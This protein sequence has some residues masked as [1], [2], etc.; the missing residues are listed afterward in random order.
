MSAVFAAGESVIE[1]RAG[2]AG[3]ASTVLRASN[4]PK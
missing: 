2:I 4:A 3:L 1:Q